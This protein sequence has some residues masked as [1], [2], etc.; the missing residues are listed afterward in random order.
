MAEQDERA[1]PA[2]MALPPNKAMKLTPGF[3]ERWPDNGARRAM[4]DPW[5]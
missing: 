5:V 3:G 4:C 2:V 1:H